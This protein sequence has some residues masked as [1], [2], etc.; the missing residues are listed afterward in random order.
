MEK[1]IL[2]D[3]N[4]TAI[5]F[6]FFANLD[7]TN[8][9]A[10]LAEMIPWNELDIIFNK[11][12]SQDGRPP[13]MSRT[14]IGS[15]IIQQ[16]E[17][18]TDAKLV[19]MIKMSPYLQMFIGMSEFGFE[20]P[21]DSSSLVHFRKRVEQVSVD[22][23]S[24]ITTTISEEIEELGTDLSKNT[25]QKVS[26]HC[27][28]LIVDAT[29]VPV[30]IAYPT[31][32]KLLNQ[33]RIKLEK[34]IN[35]NYVSG[36]ESKKPRTDSNKALKIYNQFSKLR[37]KTKKEIKKVMRQLLKYVRLDLKIIDDRIISGSF[38]LN[39]SELEILELIKKLYKQQQ[40]MFD[41]NTHSI[42]NRIVSL[43]QDH[44]RPIVRGKVNAPVE[45]GAKISCHIHCGL[46]Y[47]DTVLFDSFNES[48]I[49]E[50]IISHFY[51]RHGYYPKRVL[52][53]KIYQTRTNRSYCKKL[54]IRLQGKTAGRKSPEKIEEEKRINIKD[55][56]DRQ[57]IEGLFGVLKRKFGMDRL[58]TKLPETQK[59]S[60]GI[61]IC[62]YN[63][64]RWLSKSF[65]LK[66]QTIYFIG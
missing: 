29:A 22:I 64:E 26:S 7:L 30:E 54:G 48:T 42:T 60:I 59:V 45:F 27:G 8:N 23:N 4:V 56:A 32:S 38:N 20:A 28:D 62:V 10:V 53:D 15:L 12:N 50:E 13:I 47:L 55:N 16:R 36:S 49:L 9:Y 37:K 5:D 57:Q 24:L 17:G 21:F 40:F 58:L 34:I 44:I 41:N 6:I 33:A 61:L 18:F 66:N 25:N 51:E 14:Q 63:L 43:Q 46:A 3:L 11:T 1:Q 65:S 52:A 31:D 2:L 35:D 39:S 19:E